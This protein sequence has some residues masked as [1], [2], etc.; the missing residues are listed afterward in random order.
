M[1]F[2]SQMLDQRIAEQTQYYREF[3]KPIGMRFLLGC[4]V[5][6]PSTVAFMSAH[7]W[8]GQKDYPPRT[9]NRV[10]ELTPHVVRV[11]RLLID[12]NHTADLQDTGTVPMLR[13]SKYGLEFANAR[14][15]DWL[16]QSPEANWT[17]NQLRLKSRETDLLP[18]NYVSKVLSGDPT[19]LPMTPLEIAIGSDQSAFRLLVL[20]TLSIGSRL[21]REPAVLIIVLDGYWRLSKAHA[22]IFGL[23]ESEVQLA[24]ALMAGQSL[25]DHA[26]SRFRSIHTIRSQL[27]SLLHKVGVHTQ[28]QLVRKLLLLGASDS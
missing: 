5:V 9:V 24:N 6:S 27:K 20:P 23:S 17:S 10:R 21:E 1:Y 28:A 22:E 3:M 13:I 25:M 4:G 16:R 7:R 26:R 12:R 2:G 8:S 15:M 14:A 11:S 19:R 18:N